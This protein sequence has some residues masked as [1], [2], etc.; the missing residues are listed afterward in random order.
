MTNNMAI[1]YSILAGAVG[2]FG[3]LLYSEKASFSKVSAALPIRT[4]PI[5]PQPMDIDL[6]EGHVTK[7]M[8]YGFP[9][10]ETIRARK[11]YVLSYD[12]RNRIPNWVLEHLTAD[13]IK[14]NEDVNRAKTEFFE[15]ESIHP[16]FRATNADYKRSGYDRGHLAAAGNHRSS[17]EYLNDTFVLSNIAPQVGKGFNRDA[18][19]KLEKHVRRFVKKYQHVYVCSGP[20][21]LPRFESDGKKYVKYEV[22]GS[23]NVAVPTHFFKVIVGETENH[24]FDMEAYLMPNAPIED[25]V[26]LKAFQ[27]PKDVIE[28]AAG[29]LFFEKL[30]P[31]VFR[32]INGKR[33]T[34]K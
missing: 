7:T 2:F 27:V 3:G 23:N 10:F 13:H 21:Y 14:Y 20:L 22:I 1:R 29:L 31:T 19:N 34:N 11:S 24:E 32:H 28:R 30:S 8:Q 25:Q 5:E 26:P 6:P 16:F 4:E 12:R 18:W 33:V 9:G 15:D 17:Q